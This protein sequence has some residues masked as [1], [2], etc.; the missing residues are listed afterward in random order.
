MP[1]PTEVY[2]AR[3]REIA[4]R[5]AVL[6]A[7]VSGVEIF[8]VGRH[9]PMS[10]ET[11][12]FFNSQLVEMA[13]GY[14]TEGHRAPVVIGHPKTD[15]PAYGWVSKLRVEGDTLVADFEDI[16]PAFSELVKAKRYRKISASFYKPDAPQNPNKGRWS[17]KHVGFLGASAPA[18]KGLKEAEFEA[19]ETGI[20]SF[21]ENDF[22]DL[23]EEHRKMITHHETERAIDALIN[24]GKVLPLHKSKI[25]DF[26]AAL[27]DGQS[28]VFADGDEASKRQWFLDY[29]GQQPVAVSFG[30]AD[31][32]DTLPSVSGDPHT[33]SGYRVDPDRQALR[34]QANQ[35]AENEGISFTEAVARIEAR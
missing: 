28:V 35:M 15:A 24:A 5:N 11:L 21:G 10:G 25:M 14:D 18:V 34:T 23:P 1:T 9:S 4:A 3:Q 16:D 13:D 8:K 6:N 12:E 29:L 30:A 31:I 27:D 33:P 20:L 7:K 32:G 19:G 26:V 22:V 17:L 2:N